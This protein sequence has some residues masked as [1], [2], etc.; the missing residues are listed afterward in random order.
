MA[1][2]HSTGGESE[3]AADRSSSDAGDYGWDRDGDHPDE[4]PWR[5]KSDKPEK[6]GS[7][8]REAVIIIGCVLL[9]TW[10]LQTFIGRQYVIPS[11]SME[12]TLH[13]CAGCTNDR[14]VIDKLSYRF[15]DPSPGDVVVFK[16]PSE[17]WDGAWLSPRSENPVVHGLQD[18]LSWFGFAPPDENDLVKRV[19]ATGGQTV[20]CKNAENVGVKVNG[21]PLTEPYVDKQLQA[22]DVAAGNEMAAGPNGQPNSCYGPDFGPV[23]VP[24]GNVWVMGDNRANSADS[25]FHME[26]E[27]HGT[28]PESD[29]RGKVRFIIYP[30]SRIGGVSSH[31]PQS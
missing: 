31:N 12:Q 11:E 2:T 24:D 26:D 20:E 23:K 22:D 30:F 14:I 13:G 19:I 17:S 3:H 27:F 18:G 5:T 29:I 4:R 16:A 8:L 28:V 15:G 6:R 9:L 1:D 10:L 25:R 7:L 21:K